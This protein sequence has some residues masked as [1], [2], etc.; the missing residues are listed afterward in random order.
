MKPKIAK[1]FFSKEN[2]YKIFSTEINTPS[3][4]KNPYFNYTESSNYKN[5]N[6]E[7]TQSLS[8]KKHE[9]PSS[10]MST[11]SRSLKSVTLNSNLY[12]HYINFYTN[13]T[14]K[15]IFK[16]PRIDEYP[17]LKNIEYLPKK[18]RPQTAKNMK[19]QKVSLTKE[20]SNS[21]FLSFMKA[22]KPSKRSIQIESYETKSKYRSAKNRIDRSKTDDSFTAGKDFGEL[23]DKNLFESKFLKQIG[24]KKIDMNYFLEEKQKNFNFF[25]KYI[26][27]VNELK[28][29]S[30][31][32]HFHR[33]IIF[34]G[35]TAIKKENI[36]FKLDI[37][38]LCFKFFQLN[39]NNKEKKAQKL[40]FPF[41]LMPLFYLLDFTSFKVL[42]SEIIIFNKNENCFGF[43]KGNL[44]IKII[45]KYIDYVY[46]SLE[47]KTEYKNNITY[48][49]KETIFP[50]IY[51]WIVIKNYL[52]EED[53]NID[54]ILK[55]NFNDNY[56][57]YKLKI[58]LPKIKFC[59][60]NLNIKITKFLNKHM[61]ANI[62]QNKFNKWEKYIFFDLFSTK[63]FKIITNLIMMNKYYQIPLKKIRLN[64]NYKIKN[65]DYEFF[66]SQI[67][68]NYSLY[69]TF[70]PF[71]ILI[72]FG[73]KDKR[74]QKIIL[75]MKDS[76]NFVKFGENW[77]MI[78]TL[79]KC[80]FV[81]KMKNRIN[82]KFELLED[83]KKNSLYKAIKKKYKKNY[84]INNNH[85]KTGNLNKNINN[86]SNNYTKKLSTKDNRLKEKASNKMPIRY[87][88]KIY[89]IVLLNCSFRK[90]II[91]SN[92]SEDKYYM[93]PQNLLDSI[94][95]IKD[96][97]KIF[98]LN[99]DEISIMAKYIGENSKSILTAKESN[100]IDEEKKMVDEA[101]SEND[102]INF[103][104]SFKEINERHIS[105]KPNSFSRLK[106]F[107]L[108]QN[109]N[110]LKKEIKKDDKVE[111]GKNDFILQK[112]YSTK[113]TLP[114]GIFTVKREQK[115]VSITNSNELNQ[116][117]LENIAR[118]I[119][120]KRTFKF[121]N[122]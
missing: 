94:F 103:V 15:H 115:R 85:L 82:F 53:E 57:C 89:D 45:K 20:I 70:I 77:G 122:N 28:D 8:R 86:K 24:I 64:K 99:Y 33:N 31:E 40:Y 49:K 102:V 80:M 4:N 23:C 71:I 35:R 39:E 105:M 43:I 26:K 65:K 50:L 90:I 87:K 68:E 97:K 41:I 118:D 69:Y 92:N 25:C 107:Q 111:N 117:R 76:I 74:F 109:N 98:N 22:T 63:R 101:D 66:M 51:D 38:S 47:N 121:K 9:R 7:E 32:N 104:M 56:R 113:Y 42:L 60:D 29:I 30:K 112:R 36:D 61:I 79:F 119:A 27:E 55:N 88:D 96:E 72:L 1:K 83:D 19:K 58:V 34:N 11:L 6:N 16:T 14:K 13:L 120:K 37:Y 46:N 106:T 59:V 93:V 73:E 12:S 91:T 67:G 10:A 44:L 84:C 81:D 100:N 3:K 2:P 48:N 114:R 21:V 110:S 95:N 116:N 62:L 18:S 78:N 75:S 108:F 17:I 5:D 54:K 52:N